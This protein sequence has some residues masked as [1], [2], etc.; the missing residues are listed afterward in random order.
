LFERAIV[1]RDEGAWAVLY[2]RYH[3]LLTTW[4]R[5]CGAF[6]HINE[7]CEDLADQ[8][9]ARVDGVIS[10]AI[11]ALPDD[12]RTIGVPGLLRHD[13]RAGSRA[14]AARA[15]THGGAFR[16]EHH[17]D[18]GGHMLDQIDRMALWKLCWRMTT[19]EP[20][21]VV[22]YEVFGLAL[23]PREVL[24]RHTDLFADV[25]D[26]YLTKCRLMERLRRNPDLR[27]M[28]EVPLS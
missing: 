18:T 3:C 2:A 13:R 14:G 7:S 19:S 26:V 11:P 28:C 6:A 20:E 22:L 4:V 17:A 25:T 10:G 8:A 27:A 1:A 5:R 23:P 21:R 12:F 16:P 9:F 15:R 24:A